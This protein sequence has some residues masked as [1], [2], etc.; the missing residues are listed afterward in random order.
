M[1]DNAKDIKAIA[2][3]HFASH[4]LGADEQTRISLFLT[5]LK[6]ANAMI[7][8]K[9]E[10]QPMD[11]RPF[12]LLHRQY[13]KEIEMATLLHKFTRW[14]SNPFL[15]AEAGQTSVA[16]WSRLNINQYLMNFFS[17]DKTFFEYLAVSHA[18]MS[19]V[20][21]VPLFPPEHS[22]DDRFYAALYAIENEN[23]RQIQ[24]QIRFLKEMQ[25]PLSREE[26]E[27][28]VNTKREIVGDLFCD[29]LAAVCREEAQAAG[30]INALCGGWPVGQWQKLF[31]NVQQPV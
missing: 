28:I 27:R 6:Q 18:F 7:L 11:W 21:F 24:T 12:V 8:A 15:Y 16:F 9:N 1:S 10:F 13:Y 31:F 29:L 19:E 3:D 30:S 14:S 22:L 20:R 2:T 17:Q 23:G 26:K 25:L 5:T 4:A